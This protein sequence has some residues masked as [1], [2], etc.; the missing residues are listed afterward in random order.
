MRYFVRESIKGGRCV[1]LNQSYICI[2]S[3]DVFNI[4]IQKIEVS[5]NICEILVEYFE[6]VNKRR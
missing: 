3:D 1:A 4:I 6:Y 5:G 2:I